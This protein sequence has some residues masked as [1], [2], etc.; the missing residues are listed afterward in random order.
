MVGTEIC[1]LVWEKASNMV[2]VES[3]RH[4]VVVEICMRA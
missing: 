2:V 3:C 1:M 4:M